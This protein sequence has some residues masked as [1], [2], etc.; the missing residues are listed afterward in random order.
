MKNEADEVVWVLG[1][2]FGFAG[3]MLGIALV[4]LGAVLGVP[5]FRPH[6]GYAGAHFLDSFLYA[7]GSD[8]LAIGIV[9][10]LWFVYLAVPFATIG[11][12]VGLLLRRRR[13]AT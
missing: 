6:D 9:A 5:N 12:I 7:V 1:W 10:L 4:I 13:N 3:G 8:S 11:T 2:L